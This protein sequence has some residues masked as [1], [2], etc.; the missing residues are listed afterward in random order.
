[1]KARYQQ[2]I[3]LLIVSSYA[4]LSYLMFAK[5]DDELY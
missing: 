2:R 5:V 4:P 1:M 3:E